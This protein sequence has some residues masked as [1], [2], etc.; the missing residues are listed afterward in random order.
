[1]DRLLAS[2]DID[3]RL[4]GS[5]LFHGSSTGRWSGRGY[6]PQNLKRVELNDLDA[7][8]DAVRGGDMKRIRALGAPLTVA[9]DVSRAMICAAPGYVLIGGDFSAIES[10]VLAWLTGEKW[11]VTN[12]YEFD[13]TGDPQLE[14]C[15]T[16]TRILKRPVTPEDEADRA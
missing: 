9:G 14:P 5:L 7:A 13:R 8:V 12:Y 10:R 16:A 1:F 6:Q 11:K 2:I 4:R 3:N 15:A